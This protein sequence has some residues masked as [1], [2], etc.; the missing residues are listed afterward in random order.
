VV[1]LGLNRYGIHVRFALARYLLL[2]FV[3]TNWVGVAYAQTHATQDHP[4]QEDSASAPGLAAELF[5]TIAK[6]PV[7]VQPQ[8]G[9][10]RSGDMIITHFKPPGADALSSC[11]G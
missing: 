3:S 1:I 2:I 7:K 11:A 5:E 8:F 6:V 4:A 9:D 10:P